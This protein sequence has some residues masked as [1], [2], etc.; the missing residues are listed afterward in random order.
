MNKMN[1]VYYGELRGKRGP[2]HVYKSSENNTF[3]ILDKFDNVM[4]YSRDFESL[5]SGLYNQG[6][7]RLQ[8][9]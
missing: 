3:Y 2:L 7:I 1:A 4:G 8:L 9:E 6:E 5:F